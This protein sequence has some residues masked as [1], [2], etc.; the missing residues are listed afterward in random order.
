MKKVI[1]IIALA[2]LCTTALAQYTDPNYVGVLRRS[3]TSLTLDGVLV[4]DSQRVDLFSDIGG[5]NYNP[6]WEDALHRRTVGKWMGIGGGVVW[7]L[8]T[9]TMFS[10]AY[11]GLNGTLWAVFAAIFGADTDPSAPLEA[12]APF[13]AGGFYAGLTG[14]MAGAAGISM[15]IQSNNR[16]NRIVRYW[17]NWNYYPRPG[18][19]SLTLGP[20]PSGLGLTLSF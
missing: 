15:Y 13:V 6:D 16:M 18:E 19:V 9:A 1:L 5:I 8:G 20:A 2:L 17:N 12:S 14:F 10:A 7:V 11:S 3:G 4:S